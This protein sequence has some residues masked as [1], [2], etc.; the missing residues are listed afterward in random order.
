MILVVYLYICIYVGGLHKQFEDYACILEYMKNFPDQQNCIFSNYTILFLHV[1]KGLDYLH[2]RGIVHGDVKRF[3][4]L[5][6]VKI[7]L[8][9]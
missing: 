5:L 1:F 4:K 6:N 3:V 2:I 7:S 9:V 8:T